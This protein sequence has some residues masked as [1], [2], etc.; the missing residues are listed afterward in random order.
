MPIGIKSGLSRKP[1]ETM[2]AHCSPIGELTFDNFRIPASNRLGN[3]GDGFKMCMWQLKS[4]AAQLRRRR[5]RRGRAA[6]EAA[7]NIAISG[8]SSAR[9]SASFR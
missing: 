1:L 4:D 3:E 9:K 2:G 8:R 5:A 7:V 6:K